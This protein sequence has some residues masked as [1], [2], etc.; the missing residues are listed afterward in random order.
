MPTVNV[1]GVVEA[2]DYVSCSDGVVAKIGNGGTVMG[3]TT[4]NAWIEYT[5]NI[6]Q[7]GKY[8]YEATVSSAGSSSF[9]MALID[10]DGN[11]KTLGTISV[12]QTGS[13]DTYQVK[14]GKIRNAFKAGKQTLRITFTGGNCN[15]DK[16]KFICTEPAGITEIM[17][18]DAA[19]GVSYNLSGQK[20]GAGYKGI[21]IRNGKKVIIK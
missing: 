18:D 15:I 7:A 4:T 5:V 21:V 19:Y 2:E 12:P 8:S 1:P 10:A 17:S 16:I 3:N 20:V 9:H 14:T 13:L 11:E 6:S